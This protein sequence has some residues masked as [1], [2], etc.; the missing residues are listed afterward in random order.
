MRDTECARART[1]RPWVGVNRPCSARGRRGRRLFRLGDAP[2]A[3]IHWVDP[4][5]TGSSTYELEADRPKKLDRYVTR[6]LAPN[7]GRMT[8]PGTNTYLVGEREVA[9][10]DPG[11]ADR[12]HVDAIL[13]CGTGRIRWILLTH[14]HRDHAPAAAALKLATGATI[15]GCPAPE[16]VADHAPIVIDRILADGDPLEVDD[17]LLRAIHTPGHASNHLC[18]LLEQTHMLFS[19]DQLVQGFTVVIAPPDG[20]MRAYLHSL[21]RL[22]SLNIAILAPGHGYLIGEPHAEYDA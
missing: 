10:I 16:G 13:A 1:R 3:E 2:Y 6:I 5:E 21:E 9:V 4:Q 15:I 22:C 14:T 8:G 12:P 19:G 11:P 18:Y 17:L 7:A 20:N